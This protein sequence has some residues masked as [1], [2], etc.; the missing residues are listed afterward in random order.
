MGADLLSQPLRA[1]RCQLMP[2]PSG[3]QQMTFA[4]VAQ[5]VAAETA[6]QRLAWE[7]HILGSR[8]AC[9]RSILQAPAGCVALGS[10]ARSSAPAVQVLGIRLP[11]WTG[12]KGLFLAD[13]THYVIAIPPRSINNPAPWEPVRIWA[14]GCRSTSGAAAGCKSSGFEKVN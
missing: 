8:S 14:A 9:T 2:S 7:Q 4:F 11:G 1:R 12:G 10:G 6:A 3:M 5:Q 13:Q